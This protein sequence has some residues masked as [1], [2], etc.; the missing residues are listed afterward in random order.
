M[1]NQDIAQQIAR[2]SGVS[3]AAAADRVDGVIYQILADL[4]HGRKISL[5]GLGTF[6]QDKR[7][8]SLF[9]FKREGAGN[10]SSQG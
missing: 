10:V 7:G 6:S 5:P 1:K 3:C 2:Q 9:K 8:G 4:R